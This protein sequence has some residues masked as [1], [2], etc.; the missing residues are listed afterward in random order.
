MQ[1]AKL[2]TNGG[3]QAVRLPKD[4]RFSGSE[5]YVN[6]LGSIVVLFSKDDPWAPLIESLDEF[7]DDFLEERHQGEAGRREP[8]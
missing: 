7:P 6:K 8:L 1:T 2:F 5:V 3:S 4:C